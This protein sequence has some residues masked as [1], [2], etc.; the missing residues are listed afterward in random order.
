[1]NMRDYQTLHLDT[2]KSERTALSLLF[3]YRPRKHYEVCFESVVY[4][5]PYT[6]GNVKLSIANY[7]RSEWVCETSL[8]IDI[9]LVA[10]KPNVLNEWGSCYSI[11]SFMCIFVD[12]CLS[13][14]TFSFGHC[15]LCSSSIYGFW[16][17]LWYLQ[18]LLICSWQWIW[19][20][21]H[22]YHLHFIYL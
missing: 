7:T 8:Y 10:F 9:Y 5:L 15:I 1:M 12:R 13:F 2:N 16:L 18:T 6:M 11:C 14:C 17:P 4:D 19:V 20:H 3:Y 21:S 22:P